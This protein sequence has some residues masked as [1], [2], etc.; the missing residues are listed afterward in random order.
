[1]TDSSPR[2]MKA[3]FYVNATGCWAGDIARMA[4]IGSGSGL[5]SVPMPIV[6]RWKCFFCACIFHCLATIR[7]FVVFWI[8]M[9]QNHSR[10]RYVYVFHAPDGPGLDMPFL[11]DP[12]GVWCRR[13]GLNNIYLCG[14]TPTQ[15]SFGIN[16]IKWNQYNVI[17]IEKW[18]L[19]MNIL[20]KYLQ[21]NLL[22][23]KYGYFVGR[24]PTNQPWHTGSGLQLL[25]RAY[26]ANSGS[27]S[28]IFWETKSKIRFFLGI[29]NVYNFIV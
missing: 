2:P 27:Q 9:K 18:L 17:F 26:L 20:V 28:A 8:I 4:G 16:N 13:D 25:W 23:E 5:M 11:I 6:P 12:S 7:L 22:D 1:M 15:V 24:R 21:W 14:K 29:F 10:K 19:L 3:T